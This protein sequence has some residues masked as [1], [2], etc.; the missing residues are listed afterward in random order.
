MLVSRTV[1]RY[2]K[3][4]ADCYAVQRPEPLPA[5]ASGAGVQQRVLSWL[6]LEVA[7]A[8]FCPTLSVSGRDLTDVLFQMSPILHAL[9]DG[10][11]PHEVP[12]QLSA[13]LHVSLS[14]PFTNEFDDISPGR[15]LQQLP[16]LHACSLACRLFLWPGPQCRPVLGRHC[17]E[18]LYV[19]QELI[20]KQG[21][22]LDFCN[23]SRSCG[24]YQNL[25]SWVNLFE[26]RQR[27][28]RWLPSCT[29]AFRNRV[30]DS[31]CS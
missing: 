4:R 22:P 15:L 24:T 30:A 19:L 26:D 27:T 20:A 5:P 10:D 3:A 18:Q 31:Y 23:H 6:V 28:L 9:D 17:L 2:R 8:D 21:A 12:E 29:L 25:C 1:E 13:I 14:D 11:D 7:S 16:Q